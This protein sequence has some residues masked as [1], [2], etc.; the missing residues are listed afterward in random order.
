MANMEIFK[1]SFKGY[2]KEEVIAYIE[3]LNRQAEM[4][5]RDLDELNARMMQMEEEH[6]EYAVEKER[7]VTDE[8]TLRAA[9]AEELTPGLTQELRIQIEA[10]LRPLI[11]EEMR[12][13]LEAEMAPKYEEAARTELT[14]RIQSQAGELR[15]LRRRAQLYDDNREVL[16]ELMIKAKNDA[17]AIIKD[18]E[19]H[20]KELREDAEN[21]YRLLISDY[22]ILKSNLLISKAEAA[23][24][25]SAALKSLDDFEKKFSNM[26]Q[27]ISLSKSHLDE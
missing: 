16:A 1:T 19:Q 25:L 12:R 17:A 20:A 24:K 21:R 2:N 22:E 15:E 8:A 4:L 13:K 27:D 11:E 6:Q 5:Q 3:N 26:D 14:Q 10:E 9:I 7:Q 23:N 18:A